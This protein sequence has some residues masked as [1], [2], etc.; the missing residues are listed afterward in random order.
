MVGAAPITNEDLKEALVGIKKIEASSYVLLFLIGW[1]D[2]TDF[3]NYS[4][5]RD[6]S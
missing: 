6:Q 2:H 3:D 4:P 1:N 5:L